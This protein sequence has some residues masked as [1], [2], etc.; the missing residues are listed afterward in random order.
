M[1]RRKVIWK[2]ANQFEDWILK[3]TKTEL[4]STGKIN[5]LTT[6]T[7]M[8]P[9]PYYF[10]SIDRNA[11]VVKPKKPFFDWLQSLF[12]EDDPR[13]EKTENNIYL[14]REMGSNEQIKKW[15]K[16]NF[17]Q[18][19]ENELNDWYTDEAAWPQNRTYK[20]F[21]EWFDVEINSMILD[22]EEFPV[23]KI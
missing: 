14:I 18:L 2:I 8:E 5:L 17:N 22:I 19:F 16:K 21:E 10:E 11:I 7:D 1:E 3:G 12:P 6:E 13:T 9:I 4:G 23:T 15:I 20:M